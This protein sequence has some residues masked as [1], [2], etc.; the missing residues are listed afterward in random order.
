[1]AFKLIRLQYLVRLAFSMTLNKSQGPSLKYVGV[2]VQEQVF[3]QGQLYVA[4]SPATSGARVSVMLPETSARDRHCLNVVYNEVFEGLCTYF[5]HKKLLLIFTPYTVGMSCHPRWLH[6]FARKL[7][8]FIRDAYMASVMVTNLWLAVWSPHG[9]LLVHT[10]RIPLACST[11]SLLD[12]RPC[13]MS[14]R[15]STA[16]IP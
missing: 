6:L 5:N 8:F 12:A 13:A 14:S 7:I 16:S 15:S 1:M 11:L 3:S 4:L 10:I 2:N 9:C